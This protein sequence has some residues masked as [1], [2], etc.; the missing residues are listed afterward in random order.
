V[1]PRCCPLLRH[2]LRMSKA[3]VRYQ[4]RIILIVLALGGLIWV[5]SDQFGI[6]GED[7][8]WMLM[9]TLAAALGLIMFAALVVAIGLGLRRLLRRNP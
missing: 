5:A 6:P 2:S 7:I 3:N 9:Y 1:I 4:L 8:A